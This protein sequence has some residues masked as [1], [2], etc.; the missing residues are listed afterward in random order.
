MTQKV[1]D[2]G[3][4]LAATGDDKD[5]GEDE[6]EDD[7]DVDEVPKAFKVRAAGRGC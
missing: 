2:A 4:M 6:E 5:N 7:D 1:G 3:K